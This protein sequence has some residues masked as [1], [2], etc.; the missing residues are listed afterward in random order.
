MSQYFDG[1][2]ELKEDE[3][4]RADENFDAK[5]NVADFVLLKNEIIEPRVSAFGASFAGALA[6]P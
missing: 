5:L 2:G 3:A 6:S 4:A 1:V